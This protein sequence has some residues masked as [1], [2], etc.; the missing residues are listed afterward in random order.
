MDLVFIIH[1]SGDKIACF[2][3]LFQGF[4]ICVKQLAQYQSK[5]DIHSHTA[6]IS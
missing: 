6:I 5:A 1:K 3:E 4:K 2:G